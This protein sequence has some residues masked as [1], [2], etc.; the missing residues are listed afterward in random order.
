MWLMNL[1]SN[2]SR[3]SFRKSLFFVLICLSVLLMSWE[4]QKVDAALLN[5]A[6]PDESIRLRIL[7]HSDSPQD[8]AIKML[9]RDRVVEQMNSW[10]S[11]AT[12]IED[13]RAV[14]KENLEQLHLVVGDVLKENGQA[15]SYKVELSQVEFPTK[16]YGGLVYPAGQYEALLISLGHAEGRNWWCVLFP[17]L[18]FVDTVSGET[19]TMTNESLVEADKAKISVEAEN[20]VKTADV[21]EVNPDDIKVE[22][23]LVDAWHWITELFS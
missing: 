14:V 8:Q 17:P 4:S 7:A 18:C 2:L 11:E 19:T 9:V 21:T 5:T 20:I 22:F 12:T 10:A 16:S 23:F 3:F 1:S 13:A 6:I 15:Y